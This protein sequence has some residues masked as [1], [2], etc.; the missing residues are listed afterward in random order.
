MA[1]DL[2]VQ[3]CQTGFMETRDLPILTRSSRRQWLMLSGKNRIV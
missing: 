3:L 1:I 2:V